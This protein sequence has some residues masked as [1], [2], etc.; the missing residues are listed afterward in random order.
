MYYREYPLY[1]IYFMFANLFL[2]FSALKNCMVIFP[3]VLKRIFAL[4]KK[5]R[6]F[7]SVKKKKE[8]WI[9]MSLFKIL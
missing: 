2:D 3:K 1:S 7:L 9:I 4:K 5:K 8:N 6:L